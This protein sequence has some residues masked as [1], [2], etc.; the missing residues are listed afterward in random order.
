MTALLP[1]LILAPVPWP[2][3]AAVGVAGERVSGGVAILRDDGSA[4]MATATGPV[5]IRQLLGLRRTK[6]ALPPVPRGPVLH[7]TTGDR[8]PGR[9]TGGDG[10]VLRFRPQILDD[11][12]PDWI[13]PLSC[14][15]FVW[16]THPMAETPL[17]PQRYSWLPESRRRDFVLLRNGDVVRGVFVGFTPEI[18]LRL[19]NGQVRA[20]PLTEPLALA[21]DPTLARTRRPTGPYAHLVLRDGTRLDLTS[22]TIRD[23]VLRGQT[24]FGH[25]LE[26]PL[27]EVIGFDV[28]Q[29]KA[30]Y[31]SDLRPIRAKYEAFLG[32]EWPWSADRNVRGES[33]RLSGPYGID[34]YDKGLGTHPRTELTF[35]L[36]TRFRRFE[37]VV[38][39][40]AVTGQRGQAVARVWVDGRDATPPALRKLSGTM[41]VPVVVD[42]TGARLLVL[43]VDFGPAGD[44][45]A[46]VNWADARV[47]E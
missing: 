18:R 34:T 32:V 11:D 31:L 12:Q 27:V 10:R 35:E 1:L 4:E 44:V 37:A 6:F 43:E 14:V 41:S 39:L 28:M 17:D 30:V 9:I 7:T 24:L 3:F 45:H 19:D 13:I 15:A 42:V 21:F 22:P 20:F 40:D 26:L 5:A 25:A 33:L 23:G 47:I 38:G 16:L 46:D 2:A 8:I 36:G 29:G